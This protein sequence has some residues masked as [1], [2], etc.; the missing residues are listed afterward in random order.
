MLHCV[1]VGRPGNEATEHIMGPASMSK[2]YTGAM[3]VALF[4][5]EL[6]N[7]DKRKLDRERCL[8]DSVASVGGSG[9]SGALSW[10]FQIS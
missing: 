4:A 10:R 8:S 2:V 1:C 5:T 9:G 6:S 3:Q 7:A